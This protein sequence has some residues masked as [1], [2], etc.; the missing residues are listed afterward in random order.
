MQKKPGPGQYNNSSLLQGPKWGF[1]TE[2]KGSTQYSDA[3]ASN[4]YN[5]RS[6]IADVPSYILSSVNWSHLF[7]NIL[8]LNK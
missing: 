2:T 3:P 4:H 7:D 1:G 5:L 8:Y 6:T